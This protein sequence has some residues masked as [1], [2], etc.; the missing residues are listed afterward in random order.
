[1][2]EKSGRFGCAYADDAWCLGARITRQGRD[3]PAW[4][5]R[6]SQLPLPLERPLS[7]KGRRQAL[8]P[9]GVVSGV[10]P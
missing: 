8:R 2:Q 7:S 9:P 5:S 4:I 10:R 1:M 3:G 6:N